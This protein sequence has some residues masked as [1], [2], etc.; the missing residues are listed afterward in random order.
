M[1][2]H[3]HDAQLQAAARAYWKEAHRQL[4]VERHEFARQQ[5]RFEHFGFTCDPVP[6]G[7]AAPRYQC[8]IL[9]KPPVEP[10]LRYP[11]VFS[12]DMRVTEEGFR[13]YAGIRMAGRRPVPLPLR[14]TARTK[15]LLESL[16][17]NPWSSPAVTTAYWLVRYD[18]TSPGVETLAHFIESQA[19]DGSYSN[20]CS[21]GSIGRVFAWM[22]NYGG[23][24]VEEAN[25]LLGR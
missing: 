12:A 1:S 9:A 15:A 23:Q 17:R 18:L 13:L 7:P 2:A 4:T 16:N 14:D 20:V 22:H 24:W 8:G 5:Y 3:P 25:R 19:M 21:P 11:V 6:S 10:W